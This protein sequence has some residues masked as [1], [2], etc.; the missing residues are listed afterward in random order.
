MASEPVRTESATNATLEARLDAIQLARGVCRALEDWGFGALT[1]FSL[2]NGRRADVIAMDGAGRFIIVEIKTSEA[3]FRADK[4]WRDYL[5]FCDLFYFAVAVEFPRH[6][7]PE[8]CGLLVA[9]AYSAAVLREPDA[10]AMHPSRRKAQLLRF[11]LTA[12]LRLQQFSAP[13]L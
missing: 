5:D 6:L 9:D 8:D 3:D 10:A 12:T 4:K 13:R 2:N 1:E 7:I 11:A